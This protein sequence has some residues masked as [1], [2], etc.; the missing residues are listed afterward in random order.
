MKAIVETITPEIAAEYLSYN[1]GNR[2]ISR[3]RVDKYK[4]EM[5]SGQW[6][7]NGE[8]I[9][10]SANPKRLCDGQH[11]LIA[12]KESGVTFDSL[13]VYAHHDNFFHTL[14]SGVPRSA[15]NSLEFMRVKNARD[16][17]AALPLIDMYYKNTLRAT[18]FSS[19]YTNAEVVGLYGKYPGVEK[20]H[21]V[22]SQTKRLVIPSVA[23]SCHYLFS[24]HSEFD[25]DEFFARL[26]TGSDLTSGSPILLLRNRLIDD[27]DKVTYLLKTYVMALVIKAW[28]AWK[29]GT[30]I[31]FLRLRM[32]GSAAESFPSIFGVNRES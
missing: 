6:R 18:S 32:E 3:S 8:A 12:S 13:V 29:Q 24:R 15:A 1:T 4:R 31:K 25:S 28:N 30:G 21:P 7:L 20:S 22:R 2:S 26:S 23:I 17:A 14:D 11:R 19:Y 27:R 9:K 5:L 16:I 10:F